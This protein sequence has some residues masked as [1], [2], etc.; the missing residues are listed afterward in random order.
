V[1]QYPEASEVDGLLLLRIDAPLYFANVN[2]VRDAL[3]KYEQRALEQA[4]RRGAP[5]RFIAIDLSPVTDIDASAVHF[6]SVRAPAPRPHA[7]QA[8]ARLLECLSAPMYCVSIASFERSYSCGFA[9]RPRISASPW[10]CV[11]TPCAW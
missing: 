10:A 3:H 11:C 1:K 9:S 4:E 6:L 7:A 2:P 5:I 8:W